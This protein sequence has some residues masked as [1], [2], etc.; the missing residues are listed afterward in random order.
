MAQFLSYRC[1]HYSMTC[2]SYLPWPMEVF[3]LPYVIQVDSSGLQWTPVN[4]SQARLRPDWLVQCP[5]HWIQVQSSP[6]HWTLTGLQAT[7]QSPV[8]VQWT[9]SPV[10][11]IPFPL[12]PPPP[13]CSDPAADV[14]QH[15]QWVYP[16]VDHRPL[17]PL[18]RHHPNDATDEWR[19]QDSKR[20][21]VP[22]PLYVAWVL[23]NGKL[24]HDLFTV[25]S[26]H[27]HHAAP[28]RTT[29]STHAWRM[30]NTP[31]R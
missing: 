14:L 2:A 24:P 19:T 4:S 20:G 26:A 9:E 27:P 23:A 13:P 30:G 10:M 17:C 1:Y 18:S 5:V 21:T 16:L 3:T 25:E 11:T 22:M 6:V 12:P 31:T 28:P 7:F 15:W 8:K 29:A